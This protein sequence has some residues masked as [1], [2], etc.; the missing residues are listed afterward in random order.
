MMKNHG[1]TRQEVPDSATPDVAAKAGWKRMDG[2]LAMKDY[3][4]RYLKNLG[5][6]PEEAARLSE[7]A[8]T[9]AKQPD[10]KE[11]LLAVPPK[12]AEFVKAET[13]MNKF[14][15]SEPEATAKLL[16][17]K[18][19][20]TVDDLYNDF[21]RKGKIDE[22]ALNLLDPKVADYV[23]ARAREH[24]ALADVVKAAENTKYVAKP[25]ASADD[26]IGAL[27]KIGETE[28]RRTQAAADLSAM[29]GAAP[30]S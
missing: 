30:Q 12:S 3:S 29:D 19:Y 18:G 20:N 22:D 25:A 16:N 27:R 1:M 10:V 5:T 21:V 14:L 7:V 2:G 8:D 11:S 6:S 24:M 23:Y 26:A 4:E 15:V 9:L 28:R 17:E 13:G